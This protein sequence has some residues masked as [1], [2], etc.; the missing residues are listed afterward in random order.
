[1]ADNTGFAEASFS[2]PEDLEGMWLTATTSNVNGLTSEFSE[3]FEVQGAGFGDEIRLLDPTTPLGTTEFV[4]DGFDPAWR[5]GSL[6]YGIDGEIHRIQPDG[7]GDETITSGSDFDYDPSGA[8][9]VTAF[10]R[11]SD[12]GDDDVWL[13]VD[14]ET[15][16][17]TATDQTPENLRLDLYY[18]CGGQ[19]MPIAVALTPDVTGATT[20]S[21][22]TN[23]DPSL[24]CAGGTIEAALTDG[25]LRTTTPPGSGEPVASDPKPPVAAT[26]GPPLGSTY[27]TSDVIPFHGIGEDADDGT[28]IGASLRW[29][30]RLASAPCC[31]TLVGTGGSVDFEAGGLA[32]GDYIVTLLATDP[33]GQTDTAESLIHVIPDSDHD[34]FSDA[35]ETNTCFGA[36]AATDGSTPSGDAD[37]DG[38]PNASDPEP[39]VAATVYNAIVDF[40]PN[41]LN[42]TSSGTPITVFIQT[43]GRDIRQIVGSSV[44]IVEA[45]GAT[46]N[47]ANVGW[48]VSGSVGTAKFARQP[49]ITFLRSNGVT[50]GTVWIVVS[51]SSNT[52]PAW[53][54]TGRDTTNTKP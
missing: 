13:L 30:I 11:T 16:T 48:S 37:S 54:F 14:G 22:Q 15:V 17:V 2:I 51:G 28:L 26:Y 7:T 39:C 12:G 52:N 42:L 3:C 27:L 33:D 43:P 29:F 6:L 5:S 41:D 10:V 32:P 9:G 47:I 20:A 36:G 1:N 19:S 21:F 53:S 31:G 50:T 40:N 46:T 49:L 8:P 45:S 25:F 34:G 23:Y 4:V 35:A 18:V 24:S 38:L 44:R